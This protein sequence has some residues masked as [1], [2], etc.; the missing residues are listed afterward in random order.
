MAD[1]FMASFDAL[2]AT[3][4]GTVVT[5]GKAISNSVNPVKQVLTH[6]FSTFWSFKVILEIQR[7]HTSKIYVGN[8]KN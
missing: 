7:S 6:I 1:V 4:N 8:A 3:K 2:S 5:L